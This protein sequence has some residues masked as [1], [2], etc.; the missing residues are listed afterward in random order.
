MILRIWGLS[1]QPCDEQLIVVR[2]GIVED[3]VVGGLVARFVPL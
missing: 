3:N 2:R 1:K